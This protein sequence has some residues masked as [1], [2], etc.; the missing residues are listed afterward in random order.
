M[1]VSDAKLRE[2]FATTKTIALVGYSAHPDRPSH[3]VARFLQAKGYRVIPVNPGLAG[4]TA[5]GETVYADLA[6]IPP[7]IEVDMVDIFRR[8]EAMPDITRDALAHLPHL[9]VV[10][11]QIGVGN[12]E[13]EALARQAG[14]TVVADRCPKIEMPR[15]GL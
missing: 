1:M 13:A 2:I 4:Q 6:A 12:E 8:S 3:M 10:W 14:K 5:L 7:E 15:L 11:M 9:Q